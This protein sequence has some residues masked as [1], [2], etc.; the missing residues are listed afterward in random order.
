[1][2]KLVLAAALALGALAMSAS[3]QTTTP[4]LII[5]PETPDT[6]KVAPAPL[7]AE[8]QRNVEQLRAA[9]L[10]SDHAYAIVEDLV[11]RIGPRRAGT[12]AEARARDWAVAMLRV[13]GF[14]NPHI[15]PFD[16][17]S[18]GATRQEAYVVT[19]SGPRPLVIAALGGSA[20]T[21]PGGLEA[22]VVRYPNLDALQAAPNAD[23]AGKIVFIDEPMAR[24][25]D[26]SGYG[27]AVAKR[28]RCA[29]MAE[30]KGAV[31]C[32]IRS[33]GTNTT[34]LAHQGGSARERGGAQLPHAALSPPDADALAGLIALGPTR[35]HLDIAVDAQD[36][37]PS[38]NVLAE[39]RGRERPNEIVLVAAHLDSWDL[40]QGAIDDGAG[41]AI[42]VAAAKLIN[43][44]PKKPR[45]TIRIF[46]AGTEEP[47]GLGGIAYWQAHSNETHIVA[48][49][50]DFG[51]D[52]VWRV[53]TRFGAGAA[54]AARAIQMALAP[55]AIIPS[56]TRPDDVG[57]DV[58]PAV[59]AGVPG[60]GLDQDGTRYF[61][62]HHTADDTLH[63]IDREQLRQN[64]AAWAVFL[65]LAADTDW[66]FR[67]PAAH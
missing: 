47:G 40:G 31:A 26:G 24:T 58:A 15:E 61:D 13:E 42:I 10:A 63:M 23:V 46:L 19:P 9:A 2:K 57:T 30:A 14:S 59:D 41:D 48:G 52:R 64:V 1:M 5:P 36:R 16:I 17:Q 39:V 8:Q 25:Q 28:S 12:P 11:T 37:A 51:A 3:A 29:P 32:L 62:V 22:E 35:V 18:W 4:P 44:L 7:T 34:R 21:P 33:V 6:P 60:I 49:E 20:P 54:P 67:A 66:D 56:S 38:G 65:Y 53:E 50:S 55:L 43:D 27:V 45:R